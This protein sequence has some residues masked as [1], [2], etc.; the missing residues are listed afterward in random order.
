MTPFLAV[1]LCITLDKC[2]INAT[3][4]LDLCHDLS[5]I[6]YPEE[7]FWRSLSMKETI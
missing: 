5:T 6:D 4:G 2:N 1:E 7:D 3:I